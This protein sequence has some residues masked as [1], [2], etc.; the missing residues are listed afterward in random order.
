[1]VWS[2]SYQNVSN[3]GW[4]DY[5][6]GRG[7]GG[8]AAGGKGGGR[9]WQDRGDRG[10][11]GAKDSRPKDVVPACL[12]AWTAGMEKQM[13]A[14]MKAHGQQ[15]GPATQPAKAQVVKKDAKKKGNWDCQCGFNNFGFRAE[16]LKC[17]SP[18][19][20][21]SPGGGEAQAAAVME[22]D[23]GEEK[24][25]CVEERI[26]DLKNILSHCKEPGSQGS[27]VVINL[28]K[29]LQEAEEEA[30]QSKPPHVRLQAAMRRRDARQAAHQLSDEGVEKSRQAHEQRVALNLISKAGLVEANEEVSAIQA[31]LGR[32][33]L[34]AGATAAVQLC[35]G[36]LQQHGMNAGDTEQ[37]IDALRCAFA[38]KPTRAAAP[39]GASPFV[40]KIEAP[41]AA[42]AV[43]AAGPGLGALFS[44][45]GGFPSQG[46]SAF[47]LGPSQEE[48]AEA[49]RLQQEMEQSR[50][51]AIAS[52]KQR[53]EIQRLKHGAA[54]GQYTA[55]MEVAKKAQEAGG[56]IEETKQAEKLALEVQSEQNLIDSMESQRQSLESEAFSK[57]TAVKPI[58]A[59]PF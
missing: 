10:S 21:I 19:T 18:M 27:L 32:P 25:V 36:L 35:V 57:S 48:V 58:R 23:G 45:G 49:A 5:G 22:V 46:V 41:G 44:A 51:E 33:Q 52:L 8:A 59:S 12:K 29:E 55:A 56:G 38:A 40:V 17:G 11:W 43:S 53:L 16:C 37:F 42:A 47:P 20:V 2:G 6:N 7:R 26:K 31:E 4:I 15:G 3:G 13:A 39:V 1:M 24:G 9:P 34:E 50:A 14:L 28:K 54:A 30:R